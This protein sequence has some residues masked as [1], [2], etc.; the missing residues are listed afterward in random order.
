MADEQ[1]PS[2]RIGF[3]VTRTKAALR[4]SPATRAILRSWRAGFLPAPAV[5]RL[6]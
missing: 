3:D 5:A 4:V 2:L 1:E 6:P